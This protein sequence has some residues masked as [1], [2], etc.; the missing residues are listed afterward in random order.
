MICGKIVAWEQEAFNAEATPVVGKV[1]E[2]DPPFFVLTVGMT[3][4]VKAINTLEL[5]NLALIVLSV[6]LVW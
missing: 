6:M 4:A 5:A 2:G 1:R 3:F